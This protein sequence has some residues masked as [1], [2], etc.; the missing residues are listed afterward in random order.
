MY[1]V[2]LI[3][4]NEVE[5]SRQVAALEPVHEKLMVILFSP[6]KFSSLIIMGCKITTFVIYLFIYLFKLFTIFTINNSD[7]LQPWSEGGPGQADDGRSR[8]PG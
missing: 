1:Q 7:C 6:E 2:Q 5:K 4:V 8:R 3:S